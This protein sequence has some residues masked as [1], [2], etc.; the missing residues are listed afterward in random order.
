MALALFTL[1][2]LLFPPT[3]DNREV[4]RLNDLEYFET[5]GMDVLVYSNR[6]N[7]LFSDSKMSGIE[8][9][10]HDVRTASFMRPANW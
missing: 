8:I 5:R 1:L 7:D 4:F 6:Y 10:H 9:L 2:A 3:G